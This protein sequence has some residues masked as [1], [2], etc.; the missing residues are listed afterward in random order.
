VPGKRLP[1]VDYGLQGHRH[2][3][4]TYMFQN[5]ARQVASGQLEAGWP[6]WTLKTQRVMD[7]CFE[8]AKSGR[9]VKL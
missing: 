6:E 5:F 3:Q 2:A 1:G 7:A 9:S 8:S 4:D